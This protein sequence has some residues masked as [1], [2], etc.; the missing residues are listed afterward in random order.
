MVSILYH[1]INLDA[2][3][4]CYCCSYTLECN[5]NSGRQCNQ[6]SEATLDDG[7]SSPA[8]PFSPVSHRLT[9][10]DFE[11]VSYIRVH[12]KLE[13]ITHNIACVT[14]AGWSCHSLFSVGPEPAEPLDSITQHK[15]WQSG[16]SETEL[17]T[18][19]QHLQS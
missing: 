9:I 4:V 18:A 17:G 3:L 13:T 12:V 5:Y 11:Q 10:A 6:L 8:Q 1:N 2:V 14:A 16:W 15:L 7:R 19:N